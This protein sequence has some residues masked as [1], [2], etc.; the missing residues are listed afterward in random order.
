MRC[1]PTGWITP[2]IYPFRVRYQPV[3]YQGKKIRT[4]RVFSRDR[5]FFSHHLFF[6]HHHHHYKIDPVTLRK[7][8][9]GEYTLLTPSK[10][11]KVD[12]LF[13]KGY[14]VRSIAKT[15]KTLKSTAYDAVKNFITRYTYYKKKSFKRPKALNKRQKRQILRYIRVYLKDIYLSVLKALDFGYNV[16]IIKRYFKKQNISKQLYKKRPALRP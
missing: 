15:E 3:Q 11:F 1:Y 7:R 2:Y 8:K 10:R 4:K 13:K 5:V 12:T 16:S 9:R 14:S 6:H